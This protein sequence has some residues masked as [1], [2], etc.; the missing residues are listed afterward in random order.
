MTGGRIGNYGDFAGQIAA[1]PAGFPHADVPGS[2]HGRQILLDDP[3]GPD[4]I[5]HG[6]VIHRSEQSG[7]FVV[8]PTCH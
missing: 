4:G 7:H 1:G 5:R 8:V 3:V 6:F 2:G